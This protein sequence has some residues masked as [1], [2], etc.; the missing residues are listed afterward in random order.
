MKNTDGSQHHGLALS[1]AAAAAPVHAS[2]SDHSWNTKNMG[3][4]VAADFASAA[5][6]GV[7]V[8]PVISIIDR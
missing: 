6:A 1:Q 8:A 3:L 2:L 7:M 5:S 4:R